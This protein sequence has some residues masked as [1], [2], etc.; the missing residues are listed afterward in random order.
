M[1]YYAELEK[2]KQARLGEIG[3]LAYERYQLCKQ[4]E[5]NQKRIAEIDELITGKE[6]AAY[7]DDHAQRDFNTYLAIKESAITLEDINKGVEDASKI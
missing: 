3:Q 7:E 6:V 4:V 2:R 1:D 5:L